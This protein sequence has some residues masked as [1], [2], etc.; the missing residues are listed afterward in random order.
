M[1]KILNFP[2]LMLLFV[3]ALFLTSCEEETG[4][5]GGGGGTTLSSPT[6]T[7]NSETDITVNPGEEFTVDVSAAPDATSPLPL[8]LP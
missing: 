1:K 3:A 4:G 5:G 8:L 2:T 7:I 6:V